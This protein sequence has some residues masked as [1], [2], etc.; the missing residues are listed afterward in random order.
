MFEPGDWVWL[1]LRKER[2]PIQ[3]RSKLLPRGNGPF[4]VLECNIN[5]NAYKMDLPSEYSVSTTFNVS[6]LSPFDVGDT[7]DL[8]ANPSQED[9]ND[10]VIHATTKDMMI[11]TGPITRARAK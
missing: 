9:R 3:C 6:D 5:D 7:L 11:P 8:R 2:F 1:H 4:Q 10:A